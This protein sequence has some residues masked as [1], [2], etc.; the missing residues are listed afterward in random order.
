MLE[1][2]LRLL[3]AWQLA[4]LRFNDRV[5]DHLGIAGSDLQCLF[6]LDRNGPCTASA[7]AAGVGLTT[8]SASRMIDRLVASELVERAADTEDRRRVVVSIRPDASARLHA[9][10]DRLDDDL[11]TLLER[12]PAAA[13]DELHRFV[14]DAIPV[15][16]DRDL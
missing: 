4:V 11:R 9:I 10:Y 15:T 14:Q 3:P 16:V 13:V 8:G 5:A 7:I 12:M 1:A 2:V 6:V